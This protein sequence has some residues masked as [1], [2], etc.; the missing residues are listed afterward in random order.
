MTDPSAAESRPY[1]SEPEQSTYPFGPTPTDSRTASS[2]NTAEPTPTPHAGPS[3]E[4]RP[5]GHSSYGARPET[6]ASTPT[7]PT[8]PF[9]QQHITPEPSQ[10]TASGH[11]LNAD[12]SEEAYAESHIAG[13]ITPEATVPAAPDAPSSL[14]ETLLRVGHRLRGLLD[15]RFSELGLS[16]AR[17]VALKIIREAAPHGCTQAHLA[18][19]LG[20]CESSISTLVERMRTSQLLYRLRSKADRRKRVLMLTEDGR[21]LLEDASVKYEREARL[22]C[23]GLTEEERTKLADLM[24]ELN[25]GLERAES[26]V[27]SRSS[28]AA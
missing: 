6:P 19:K 8:Y 26:G 1:R 9:P 27:D 13:R 3:Q 14:I 16:D 5:T 20:Q 21:R 10:P 17:F 24:A 7:V 15:N 4:P 22:L 2:P 25:S 18:S 11:P 23:E 28:N 12:S